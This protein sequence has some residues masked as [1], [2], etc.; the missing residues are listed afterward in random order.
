M[1]REK[2]LQI[3]QEEIK[4]EINFSV[5][6]GKF[7]ITLIKEDF[8]SSKLRFIHQGVDKEEVDDYISKF[9]IIRDKK[10]KELFDEDNLEIPVVKDQRNNI[11]AYRNFSD[12]K[13]VVDYINGRRQLK[14]EFVDINITAKPIYEGKG[15]QIYYADSP[16]ACITY[17]GDKPYQWCINAKDSSNHFYKYRLGED[18]PS[19]YFVKDVEKTEKEFENWDNETEF[20]GKF[21]D[22]NHFIVI[23]V[24]KFADINDKKAKQYIFTSA[25]N[26]GDIPMNWLEIVKIQPNLGELQSILKPQP[27]TKDEKDIVNKYKKGVS[28]AEFDNMS[29]SQRKMYLQIYPK[30]DKLLTDKQFAMLPNDL[31]NE[32]INMGVGLTDGQY[33]MIKSNSQLLDRYIFITNRKLNSYLKNHF[34]MTEL[35]DSELNVIEPKL[36]QEYINTFVTFSGKQGN[37]VSDKYLSKVSPNIQQQYFDDSVSYFMRFDVDIADEIL[38]KASPNIK[39][40]YI[41]SKQKNDTKWGDKEF[42]LKALRGTLSENNDVKQQ[43]LDIINKTN[44]APNSYNTWIRDI[45]DIRSAEEVFNVQDNMY[46]DWTIND[47]KI[48]L[49]SGLVTVYSSKPIRNGVFVTPSKMYAQEY[50]GGKGTKVYS[51][52]VPL[53]DVAW[54]DEGEGQY[55]KI[56]NIEKEYKLDEQEQYKVTDNQGEQ[57]P[58]KRRELITRTEVYYLQKELNRIFSKIKVNINIYFGF[59]SHFL[60]RLNDQRNKKDITIEE[61]RNIFKSVYEVYKDQ[62]VGFGDQFKGMFQSASTDINI[63]FVLIWDDEKKE[64]DLI[65]KTIMRKQGFKTYDTVLPVA[66]SLRRQKRC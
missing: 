19:F 29:Y 56:K 31:Q 7:N 40:K 4:N 57:I 52:I 25:N 39:Q 5:L 9:K 58:P 36:R 2:I 20:K 26:N 49:K 24:L 21:K 33:N 15:L 11:D 62:L 51:K 45:S 48:S 60:E 18:E 66:E 27:L 8:K 53:K 1:S 38:S 46:E 3:I 41:D 34:E 13:K 42:L 14:P 54:I 6:R 47:M 55:A 35:K 37:P 59:K 32:Y 10:F 30:I 63:P 17:V 22:E 16:K 12:L 28:E 43:Q 50:A 65:P 23:Q 64:M 44:P 61:L